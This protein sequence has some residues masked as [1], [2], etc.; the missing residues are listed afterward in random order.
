MLE[1]W[2]LQ[3]E[4]RRQWVWQR[5]ALYWACDLP[6]QSWWINQ[7]SRGQ[8]EWR[9]IGSRPS[10]LLAPVYSNFFSSRPW[11]NVVHPIQM[12]GT[13]WDALRVCY[14]PWTTIYVSQ[15]FGTFGKLPPFKQLQ[16]NLNFL[17][18]FQVRRNSKNQIHKI[19]KPVLILF[20]DVNY[21]F[22]T[23]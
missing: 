9:N 2:A 3:V 22:F 8:W 16:W 15:S 6:K 4:R 19:N 21:H 20:L 1:I 13:C 5:W 7:G 10:L 12:H 23:K 18:L 17:I 14:L 11:H